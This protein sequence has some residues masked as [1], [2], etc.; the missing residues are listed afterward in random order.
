M[1]GALGYYLA[2]P[3]LYGI[4]LLPF[5]LLYLLSDVLR[6]LLFG[7]FG[8]RRKVVLTNLRNSFPEKSE[9]GIQRIRRRFE[10]WFC[11]LT[12]ETIKT[13]TISPTA[14]RRRVDFEGVELLRRYAEQGQSVV[15]VLGHFGNWELAGARYSAEPGLPQLYVIYHP[16]Q[17]KRFDRLVHHMRTRHG[18]RLYTM[19][20][21]SKSMLRDRHL[22][23][24]TAFIADQ[25]PAPERAHWMTFL[26]QDTP[27]FQGTE[28][29][30]R[31]LG[32][33]VVYISI[34]RPGRGHYHLQVETLVADPRSTDEGEIT[35]IHTRRLEQDIINYPDLWLW[36]H[37][38]WKHQRPAMK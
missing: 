21:T 7:V 10:Q 8:Y 36:T 15:L 14:V 30:S 2:L 27:V 13:L 33:P 34:T 22:N 26:N 38:R 32:Y 5:P 25:T 16:L 31:K 18:T 11:D 28:S 9:E 29:L 20:E 19:R 17:N 23:T 37:R 35:E 6:L 24:A 1:I 12:L 3:F 4:A